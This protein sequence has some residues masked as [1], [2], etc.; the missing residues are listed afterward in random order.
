GG[1]R[2]LGRRLAPHGPVDPRAPPE[3]A[4]GSR[5]GGAVPGRALARRNAPP[6]PPP[7]WERG[8]LIVTFPFSRLQ[9]KGSP[10]HRLP[11]SRVRRKG[12]WGSRGPMG[13]KV[14]SPVDSPE[15]WTGGGG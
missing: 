6:P 15:G 1:A 12:P 11:L 14:G 3:A 8:S 13:P 7:E 10:G 4:A 5:A 9:W 2:W